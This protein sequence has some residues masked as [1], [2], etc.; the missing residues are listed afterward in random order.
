LFFMVMV[1][2]PRSS[3]EASTLPLNYTSHPSRWIILKQN[4]IILLLILFWN[5]KFHFGINLFS[6]LMCELSAIKTLV[7]DSLCLA[8]VALDT[9]LRIIFS[10][11]PHHVLIFHLFFFSSDFNTPLPTYICTQCYIQIDY[12][13]VS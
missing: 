8:Q 4:F 2:K 6:Y 5:F 13:P 11:F 1:I 3:C 10:S 7:V 9:S 12:Y